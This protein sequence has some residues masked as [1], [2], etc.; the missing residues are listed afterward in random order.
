MRHTHRQ[1]HNH[2][3]HHNHNTTTTRPQH[4]HNTT[5]TRPQHDQNTTTTQQQH[6]NNTTTQQQHNNNTTTTTTTTQQHNNTTAHNTQHTTTTQQHN[7][8]QQHNNTTHNNTTH[9]TPH[10]THN[11]TKAVFDVTPPFKQCSSDTLQRESDTSHHLSQQGQAHCIQSGTTLVQDEQRIGRGPCT[12][13]LVASCRVGGIG[14]VWLWCCASVNVV[15]WFCQT[16]LRLRELLGGGKPYR[17]VGPRRE[18]S[19]GWIAECGKKLMCG[20]VGGAHWTWLAPKDFK[21]RCK[22]NDFSQSRRLW[23]MV[24][25]PVV[26]MVQPAVRPTS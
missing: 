12:L 11:T 25:M 4:D 23:E 22:I 17:E 7:T 18:S 14:G 5:T 6:N 13:A 9:N 3:N 24:K 20:S 15:V 8:Q 10:N 21:P 19:E 16:R 1:N 2:H 26:E